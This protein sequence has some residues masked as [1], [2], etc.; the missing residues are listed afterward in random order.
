[1][2]LIRYEALSLKKE[3]P[4]ITMGAEGGGVDP[5]IACLDTRRK[6]M[7]DEIYSLAILSR[8]NNSRTHCLRLL[9]SHC[10]SVSAK[11]VLLSP[12]AN[13]RFLDHPSLSLVKIGRTNV[14][15]IFL[16]KSIS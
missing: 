10:P 14:F 12:G 8:G 5:V 7:I 3:I 11:S 2:I 6:R 1:M 15:K 13:P 4:D 16:W 9:R